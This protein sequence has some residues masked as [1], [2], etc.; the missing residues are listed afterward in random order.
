MGE[1]VKQTHVNIGGGKSS[2]HMRTSAEGG[3]ADTC[4]HRGMRSSRH[5][6]TLGKGRQADTCE[7]RRRGVK[8]THANI[9]GG[10]SSRHMRRFGEGV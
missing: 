9:G 3:Q 5:M 2:R 4:E 1:G 6:Q 7:H 8:Q 10:E